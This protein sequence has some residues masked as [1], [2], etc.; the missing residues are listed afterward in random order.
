MDGHCICRYHDGKT[1]DGGF[2][3]GKYSGKGKLAQNNE[4]CE[5]TF[6][7]GEKHGKSVT[8]F[9]DLFTIS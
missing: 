3:E 1:Y 5:T 4:V 6:L 2:K 7:E 9:Y 8:N